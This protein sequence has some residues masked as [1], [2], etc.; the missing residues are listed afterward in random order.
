[1]KGYKGFDKN[2][3][4]RDFQ[5]EIG[6]EYT[7]TG[8]VSLC[9]SGF[10]FC[11]NPLDVLRYYQPA[12][13]RYA[14]IEA[15]K[16]S[17]EKSDDSKRTSASLKVKAELSLSAM[18]GLGVKS[19]LEKSKTVPTSGYYSRAATSGYYSP[20]ATSGKESIAAAIGRKA[21]AKAALGSWIV[22]AEYK[23]SPEVLTVKTAKVDG[24]KLKA[25][26]FYELKKGKF[27]VCKD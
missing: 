16:V 14:E 23:N 18:I 9:N 25:D 1:M 3:K 13:S 4:C 20:A 7:H 19:S 5:F 11:E 27:V 21:R 10:H 17:D 8:T 24:K 6:K 12:T 22:L 2:L 26:T 15:E